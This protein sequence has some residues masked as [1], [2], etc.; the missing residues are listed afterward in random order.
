MF[1]ATINKLMDPFIKSYFGEFDLIDT[2][3]DTE[4]DMSIN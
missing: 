3:K 1:S 4:L 2:S